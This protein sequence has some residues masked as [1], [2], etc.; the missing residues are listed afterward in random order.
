MS[1]K[2]FLC[3]SA[4]L[5][6]RSRVKAENRRSDLVGLTS[7]SSYALVFLHMLCMLLCKEAHTACVS[8]STSFQ[9]TPPVRNLLILS[10]Q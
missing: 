3:V 7:G 10:V 2:T 1:L 8:G 5:K 9:A 6:G 4:D